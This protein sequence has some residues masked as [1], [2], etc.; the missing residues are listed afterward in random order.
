MT[1]SKQDF[2]RMTMKKY[3]NLL[4]EF[5]KRGNELVKQDMEI[6]RLKAE[7]KKKDQQIS[8]YRWAADNMREELQIQESRNPTWR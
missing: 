3:L 1:S 7:I 2:K 5:N 8:D 4:D 6:A